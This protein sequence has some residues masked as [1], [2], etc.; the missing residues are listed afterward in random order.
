[1]PT[2]IPLLSGTG[3][4]CAAM[5]H[6][7]NLQGGEQRVAMACE[8]DQQVC[9]VAGTSCGRLPAAGEPQLVVELYGRQW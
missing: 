4:S 2:W 6:I 5:P 8:S 3:D 7:P 9:C 1:V